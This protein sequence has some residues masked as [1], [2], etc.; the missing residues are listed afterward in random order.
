MSAVSD[1]S[2]GGPESDVRSTAGRSCP[3][4]SC[5][6]CRG[7]VAGFDR[8]YN[9]KN[10]IMSDPRISDPRLRNA[11]NRNAPPAPN[12]A[13]YGQQHQP[14]QQQQQQQQQAT[15]SYG[16]QGGMPPAPPPGFRPP[17]GML[18]AG[19]A[20]SS[21]TNSGQLVPSQQQQQG[22]LQLAGQSQPARKRMTFCVVCASNQN[23]SM[24][25][26]NVLS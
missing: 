7:V 11:Y 9:I 5:L 13:S 17:P 24:E 6:A 21:S 10:T 19:A 26:H 14:F 20:S 8:D 25:G 16:S 4:I 18:S 1:I 23:R 15:A 3:S 22:S 12:G 2:R